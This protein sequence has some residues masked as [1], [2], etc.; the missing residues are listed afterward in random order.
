MSSHKAMNVFA[1]S[2]ESAVPIGNTQICLK[3]LPPNATN[4]SSNTKCSQELIIK[5]KATPLCVL[6][7]L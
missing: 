7:I 5:E 2:G 3:V 4:T 6:Q 1:A